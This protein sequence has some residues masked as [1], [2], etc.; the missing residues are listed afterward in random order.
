MRRPCLSLIFWPRKRKCGVGC[1][2]GQVRLMSSHGRVSLGTTFEPFLARCAAVRRL[3]VIE[4]MM[5]QG[6]RVEKD[7][8]MQGLLRKRGRG[9]Y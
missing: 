5:L 6:I 7:E 2:A 3:R 1:E 4:G 8:S 9:R